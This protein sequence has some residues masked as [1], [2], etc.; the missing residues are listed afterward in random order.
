VLDA[1]I[2]AMLLPTSTTLYYRSSHADL[3]LDRI[4]SLADASGE[5]KNK[6]SRYR[7]LQIEGGDM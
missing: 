5:H 4:L 2:S 1:T 6:S 7:W 3:S